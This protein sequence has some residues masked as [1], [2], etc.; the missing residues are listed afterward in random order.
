MGRV[1]DQSIDR[2]GFVRAIPDRIQCFGWILH[3]FGRIVWNRL[4]F[5]GFPEVEGP[6]GVLNHQLAR[7]AIKVPLCIRGWYVVGARPSNG[8]P[9]VPERCAF[10]M[11]RAFSR[12]HGRRLRASRWMDPF[13][14]EWLDLFRDRMD[15][16]HG[17]GLHPIVSFGI[18]WNG[19]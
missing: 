7:D 9:S 2:F 15:R 12:R 11:D 17:S 19:S 13:H 18:D 3:R 1:S 8:R 10:T 14:S 5:A 4:D 6:R 16:L